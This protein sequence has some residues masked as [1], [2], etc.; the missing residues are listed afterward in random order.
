MFVSVY[1][2]VFIT[3]G[4]DNSLCINSAGRSG[5]KLF[6]RN[7][8]RLPLPFWLEFHSLLGGEGSPCSRRPSSAR[9]RGAAW[10]VGRFNVMVALSAGW[11]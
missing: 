11:L 10:P 1:M 9:F 8:G 2:Y 4:G 5:I 6:S 3:C 7:S